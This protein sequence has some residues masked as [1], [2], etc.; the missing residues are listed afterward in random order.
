[1][2]PKQPARQRRGRPRRPPRH[3]GADRLLA[4]PDNDQYK[5]QHSN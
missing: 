3:L 5:Q 1:M 4:D 2:N